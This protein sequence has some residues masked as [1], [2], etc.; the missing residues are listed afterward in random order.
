MGQDTMMPRASL[1][2]VLAALAALSG[3]SSAEKCTRGE[4]GCIARTGTAASRLGACDRGLAPN[5]DDICV[6]GEGAIRD[7]GVDAGPVEC[8]S[9]SLEEACERF[10]QAFCQNEDLLCAQSRCPATACDHDPD[11]DPETEN[12]YEACAKRCANDAN[13]A[14]CGNR[15]CVAEGKR[16]CEDFGFEDPETDVFIAGCFEDDPLCVLREDDGCSD[17]CGT[18]ANN[19]NGELAG[20]GICEDGGE[21]SDS[22]QSPACPRGTDCTDCGKRTCAAA[23]SSC[24]GHGDCCGFYGGNS[25]CVEL[26]T[27]GGTC[28]ATCT[29]T[30]VCPEGLSCLAVD[31]NQNYVC[32]P[33]GD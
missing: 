25:F 29:E 33:T 13:P 12:V 23:G 18:L 22:P 27:S 32:A 3:C 15:L 11:P 26:T 24:D 20:N 10:C 14:S 6:E 2:F 1:C 8:T 7:G 28:L 31:D 9:D 4:E 16:T 30:R 21:G 5:R 17:T 19:T